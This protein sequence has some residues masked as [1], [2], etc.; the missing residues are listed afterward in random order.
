MFRTRF[1]PSPTGP[2]HLG[3]TYSALLGH[4][5]AQAHGGQFLLRI[6]D[7]DSL[8]SR[9][10]RGKAGSK[11]YVFLRTYTFDFKPAPGR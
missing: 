11:H 2:L 7:T 4:D 1:A 3:H 10:R 6:E 8:R 5:M 9:R